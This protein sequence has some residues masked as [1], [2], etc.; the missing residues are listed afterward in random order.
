M[1]IGEKED[2][3]WE[4]L[5]E[6]R[7]PTGTYHRRGDMLL[8]GQYHLVVNICIFNS[9]GQML[10][11]KR[12]PWKKSWPGLW[13][14][15]AGGSAT[16]GDTSQIAAQRETEEEIGYS[17]D[18]SEERPYFTINGTKSFCDYYIIEEDLD[19]NTLSLQQEEV[20]EVKWATKEEILTMIQEGTFVPYHEGLIPLIFSMYTTQR[21]NCYKLDTR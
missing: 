3:I 17:R 10:I 15:S 8:E 21:G 6:E 14:V 5:N 2:E 12:Q 7:Q 13:N 9:M 18:F 19:I 20:A 16:A 1:P 4:I 11:Q